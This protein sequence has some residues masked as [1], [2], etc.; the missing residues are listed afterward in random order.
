MK[1][2]IILLVLSLIVFGCALPF[3]FSQEEKNP[4]VEIVVPE[5]ENI[6]LGG[7]T[8]SPGGDK[9]I[10]MSRIQDAIYLVDL[11]SKEKQEFNFC[12]PAIWLDNTRVLCKYESENAFVLDIDDFTKIQLTKMEESAIPNLAE[13]LQTAT[14]IYKYEEGYAVDEHFFYL[15]NESLQQ[16]YLV[17]A[18]SVD[19][20]LEDYD[21]SVI[22]RQDHSVVGRQQTVVPSFDGKHYFE[23]NLYILAIYDSATQKVLVEYDFLGKGTLEIGGWAADSSGVYFQP[24]RGGGATPSYPGPIL[25]LKVPE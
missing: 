4:N 12:G 1:P 2:K 7:W 23:Y 5:S 21:Y 11:E 8:L 19:E 13:L 10:Y 16:N 3:S 17:I 6:R 22:P 18:E 25:K 14:A 20:V 9:L 24:I 15:L